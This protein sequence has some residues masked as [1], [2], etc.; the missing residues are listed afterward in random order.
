MVENHDK[1]AIKKCEEKFK[2]N[3]QRFGF[4]G[5]F[6]FF[7]FSSQRSQ[8][9]KTTPEFLQLQPLSLCHCTERRKMSERK[10]KKPWPGSSGCI[11][12]VA[13]SLHPGCQATLVPS[14]LST[15]FLF[16][17]SLS[18]KELSVLSRGKS[19]FGRHTKKKCISLSLGNVN[20]I[21]PSQHYQLV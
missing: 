6:F 15:L 1:R 13:V 10:G 17:L 14:A 12:R 3:T 20:S 2:G 5:F 21:T 9:A 18:G 16:L 8:R 4:L 11:S 19:G 7:S